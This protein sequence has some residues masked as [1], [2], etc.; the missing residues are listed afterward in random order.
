M[1]GM[2]EDQFWKSNPRIIKVYEEAW[3]NEVNYKNM[4]VHAWIGNYGLSAVA[5][6][7]SLVLTPMFC[8]GK[9]SRAKYIEEPIRLF[10]KTEEE[11][12]AEY[13]AMTQA[14]LSWEKN[15]VKKY[16]KKPNE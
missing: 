1:Y 3:R 9:Q 7:L 15:I 4:V 10:P 2:T 6:A 11:K 13:E 5:T 12:Q 8:K 14:L 16:S